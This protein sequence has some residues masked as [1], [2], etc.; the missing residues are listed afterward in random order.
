MKKMKFVEHNRWC[1]NFVS[2]TLLR[3][4]KNESCWTNIPS[5]NLIKMLCEMFRFMT[6]SV[7]NFFFKVL[8]LLT[9]KKVLNLAQL[10]MA[11]DRI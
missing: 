9:L 7:S 4:G 6:F 1:F 2:Q 8:S 3:K 11:I 5:L 10:E